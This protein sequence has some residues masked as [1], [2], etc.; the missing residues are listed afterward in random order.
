VVIVKGIERLFEEKKCKLV[1][2]LAEFIY[3]MN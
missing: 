1:A 2:Q 3:F